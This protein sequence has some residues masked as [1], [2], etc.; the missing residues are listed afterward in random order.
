MNSFWVWNY[1]LHQILQHNFGKPIELWSPTLHITNTLIRKKELYLLFQKVWERSKQNFMHR[2]IRPLGEQSKFKI[3]FDN[4][5]KVFFIEK[6]L[7]KK[8][9]LTMG[10]HFLF[11]GKWTWLYLSFLQL[12][13]FC[14][15]S[16]LE[17]S[18]FFHENYYARPS[19]K[20]W[21][22]FK[23]VTIWNWNQNTI[24]K[25]L[26]NKNSVVNNV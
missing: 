4:Y 19:S 10:D 12:F 11:V 2:W 18:H 3:D 14:K 13:F 26:W 6:Q 17:I 21:F 24:N 5:K 7:K 9:S 23:N 20:T 1:I 16:R 25:L 15:R 8:K 22:C